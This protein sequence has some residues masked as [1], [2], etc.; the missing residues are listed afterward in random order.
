MVQ[1]KLCSMEVEAAMTFTPSATSSF[2]AGAV[3]WAMMW[4]IITELDEIAK[5]LGFHHTKFQVRILGWVRA[6]K[7]LTLTMTELVNY[8]IHGVS[9]PLGVTFA[10]GGTLMNFFIV[11]FVVPVISRIK[12]LTS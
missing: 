1:A 3:F 11:M 5:L 10:L 4:C 12:K 2:S 8:S 9:N 6:H 7:V